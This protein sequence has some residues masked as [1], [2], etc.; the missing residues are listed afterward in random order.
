MP[1]SPSLISLLTRLLLL[2]LAQQV[3]ILLS[4]K[5][6]RIDHGLYMSETLPNVNPSYHFLTSS[7]LLPKSYSS[8]AVNTSCSVNPNLSVQDSDVVVITRRLFKSE[9][10]DS[11]EIRVIPVI[12]P[13]SR[14][15]LVL[16]VELNNPRIK[17]ASSFQYPHIYASCIGVSYSS[18]RIMTFF[19]YVSKSNLLNLF[20]ALD[21]CSGLHVSISSL[22]YFKSA[23]SNI[24]FSANSR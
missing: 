9:K 18:R 6:E 24:L 17:S 21:A 14:F 11:F 12:K 3:S 4:F 5:N 7:F 20:R 10:I 22:K 15:L 1:L 8:S 13:R 19:P 23:A 2:V 16:N